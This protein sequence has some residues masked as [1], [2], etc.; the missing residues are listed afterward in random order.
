MLTLGAEVERLG[1]GE[2]GRQALV[3]PV[4]QDRHARVADGPGRPPD[5]MQRVRLGLC[6]AAEEA[7][8]VHGGAHQQPQ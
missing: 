7:R 5:T 2:D 6:E 3:P 1:T 4:R 8:Q